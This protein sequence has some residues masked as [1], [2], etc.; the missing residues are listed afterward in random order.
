MIFHWEQETGQMAYGH[1]GAEGMADKRSSVLMDVKGKVTSVLMDAE[2]KVSSELM[3]T[4]RK[5]FINFY[6]NTIRG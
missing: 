3:G 4:E 6:G 2:G 5:G 1:K